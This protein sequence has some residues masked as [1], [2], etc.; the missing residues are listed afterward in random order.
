MNYDFPIDT[1]GNA[2]LIKKALIKVTKTN[3]FLLHPFARG[4][5]YKIRYGQDYAHCP[6]SLMER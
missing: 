6:L 5:E 3:A 4:G 1:K 2:N